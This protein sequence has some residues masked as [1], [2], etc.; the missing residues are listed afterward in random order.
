MLL[1]PIPL[2]T[3]LPLSERRLLHADQAPLKD[4]G[5]T[6]PLTWTPQDRQHSLDHWIISVETRSAADTSP[7]ALPLLPLS[8]GH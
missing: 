3:L 2:L 1:L 6:I 7:L 4:C 5:E 8:Y